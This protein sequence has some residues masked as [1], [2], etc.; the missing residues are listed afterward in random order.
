MSRGIEWW[1][2][3]TV[4]VDLGAVV[5]HSI[6]SMQSSVVCLGISGGVPAAVCCLGVLGFIHSLQPPPKEDPADSQKWHDLQS[7]EEI[8]TSQSTAQHLLVAPLSGSPKPPA[9][10]SRIG[11]HIY[12]LFLLHKITH[13]YSHPYFIPTRCHVGSSLSLPSGSFNNL[14]LL[15]HSTI[16]SCRATTPVIQRVRIPFS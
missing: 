3:L 9:L 15:F 12:S 10:S 2:W 1:L 7:Y 5:V 4:V 8:N 16:L 11:T 6:R 13:L 14:I